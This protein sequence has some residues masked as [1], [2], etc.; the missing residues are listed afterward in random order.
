MSIH[1]KKTSR[2]RFIKS[3]VAGSLILQSCSQ[4]NLKDTGVDLEQDTI[5]EDR[6]P[7][8]IKWAPSQSIDDEVFPYGI[9]SGDVTSTSAIISVHSTAANAEIILMEAQSTSWVEVQRIEAISFGEGLYQTSLE[10]LQPD[11]AYNICA[12][13]DNQNT[14][15]SKNHKGHCFFGRV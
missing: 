12:F 7:E 8:P 1:R 10:N 15:C 5:G 6:S 3:T 2:R 4:D 13:T 11:T 14:T 9:Q